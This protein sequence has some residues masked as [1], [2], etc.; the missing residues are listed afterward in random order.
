ME[1]NLDHEY[2]HTYILQKVSE[3]KPPDEQ[4]LC[5]IIYKDN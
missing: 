3:Q 2:T 4:K 1:L 5:L